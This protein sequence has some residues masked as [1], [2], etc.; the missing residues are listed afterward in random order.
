M[1]FRQAFLAEIGAPLS[2]QTRTAI[3]ELRNLGILLRY[4]FT[5]ESGV[6]KPVDDTS[7]LEV[8]LGNGLFQTHTELQSHLKGEDQFSDN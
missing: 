7:Q 1:L 5:W 6:E 2:D 8:F 3:D 4:G